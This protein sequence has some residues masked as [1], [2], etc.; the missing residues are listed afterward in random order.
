MPGPH[1]PPIEISSRLRPLLK[2]LQRQATAP[3]R[4]VTRVHILLMMNRQQNQAETA[5]RRQ[6]D[7][8][9]VRQWGCRWRAAAQLHTADAAGAPRI[10]LRPSNGYRSARSRVKNRRCQTALAP[11]GVP[12]S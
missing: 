1:T 8:S 10:S 5:R 11:T 2:Q 9:T 6:R 4:L 7:R 12:A 3:Q